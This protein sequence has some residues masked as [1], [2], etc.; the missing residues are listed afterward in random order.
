[1]YVQTTTTAK[2]P[3]TV[4]PAIIA[5]LGGD[6]EGS[7]VGTTEMAA[8]VLGEMVSP[9]GGGG[10]EGSGVGTTKMAAAVAGEMVSPLDGGGGEGSGVGSGHISD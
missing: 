1:M 5:V 10:G 6:G 4:A 2:T 9:L 3:P 8:A 7:G